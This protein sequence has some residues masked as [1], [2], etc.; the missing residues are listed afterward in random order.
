MVTM[1]MQTTFRATMFPLC[2]CLAMACATAATFLRCI[3]RGYFP[4]SFRSFL[5]FR[6]ECLDEK[7]PSYIADTFSQMMVF[8][9]PFDIEFFNGDFVILPQQVKACF[10][11]KV[12]ALPLHFKM[13]LCQQLQ[14]FTAVCATFLLT[15]NRALRRFQTL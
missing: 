13:L 11:G 12:M 7:P 8:H 6:F 10:V 3:R 14:S 1:K 2:Q 4:D 9:H 5:R 15:A